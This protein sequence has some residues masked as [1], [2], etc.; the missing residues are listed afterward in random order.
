MQREKKARWHIDY[1]SRH[2]QIVHIHKFP[3]KKDQECELSRRIGDK[4]DAAVPVKGFGSSDCSCISHL[5]L[6]QRDPN[7]G[8]SRLEIK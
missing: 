2:G 7:T 4:K 6:F 1:L 8:I 3:G 5:Y